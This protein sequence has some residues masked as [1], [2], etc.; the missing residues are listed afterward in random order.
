MVGDWTIQMIDNIEIEQKSEE[1]QIHPSNVQRDYVFS[2]I[3]AGMYNHSKLRD[4]LVLKGGNCLRKVYFENTRFSNDLDFSCEKKIPIRVLNTEFDTICDFVSE[5][6]GIEFKKERTLVEP[7]NVVDKEII[8]DVKLYFDDFY[9]APGKFDIKVELDIANFDRIYLP[10]QER[11]LIHPYSDFDK[12]EAKIRCIKLEEL[13]ASK[14]KCLLQR[15]HIKDLYDYVYSIFI[16]KSYNVRRS[17]I[18]QVFFKKTIYEGASGVVRGLLL[19]LPFEALRRVW[20]KDLT[21]PKQSEIVYDQA[22]DTFKQDVTESFPESPG[23]ELQLSY[24][25]SDLRT[26]IMEAG[27]T[28]TLLKLTYKG[29]ERLVEPYSLKYKIRKDGVGREYFYAYDTTG[30]RSGTKSIKSFVN[31]EIESLEKTTEEFKPQY[32]I[33]VSKAGEFQDRTYFGK[34][35]PRT[36]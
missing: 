6:T 2:W 1:F 10:V 33:E 5:Q 16:N 25:P 26:K 8:Y 28:K 27:K 7:K 36:P 13:L 29:F 17:E 9:G 21:V 22:V 32:L 23:T 31:E 4:K 30:G 34:S 20:K 35:S 19:D 11:D 14:L 18:L 15:R 24:F 3:L 12:C